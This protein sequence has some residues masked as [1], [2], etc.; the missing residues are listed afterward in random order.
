VSTTTH[1]SGPRLHPQ[2]GAVFAALDEHGIAWALLRGADELA[3]PQGDVDLLAD[4]RRW[5]DVVA[6][7]GAL[8][9]T[10]MP[11][12]GYGSHAF[13]LTYDP[14]TDS[15]IKLDIVTDLAFGP[16][17]TLPSRVEGPVLARR[18]RVDGVWMLADE[19][20]FWCLVLHKLLD[21]GA[22]P[23]DVHD[24]L[25][26]LAAAPCAE[27]PLAAVVDR[28]SPPGPSAHELVGHVR[29]G[30]WDELNGLAGSLRGGWLRHH[31]LTVLRRKVSH[32]FWKAAG[33]PLRRLRRQGITVA[34]LGPDGAGKS[35]AAGAIEGSFYF[36][37][38]TIYMGPGQPHSGR[39]TPP[40]GVG[41]ALRV[42]DQQRRWL[43][44]RG[45]TTRGQLVLFDRYSF[46]AMLPPRR[47]ISRIGR[48]RR[49]LLARSVPRPHLTIILDAPGELL[50]AR[51]GEQ[52][53]EILEA[54]R[55]SY[56][57]LTRRVPA[58]AVID[59]TQ[60]PDQVR[61]A[62]TTAIWRRWA[63]RWA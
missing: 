16:G 59:A 28:I 20:A 4:H 49:W 62:I 34:L 44:A 14:A 30:E 25:R 50:H 27:S 39:R 56:L 45:R 61:K 6:A 26:V 37:T 36:P 13:F 2:L 42:A 43:R 40:P 12:W 58:A 9:F 33:K 52:T 17:F 11:A 1:S 18:R 24:E 48:V 19:D 7:L 22:V 38:H 35:T 54:E 3:H 21:K 41:F 29:R 60:Q 57:S 53:P 32:R 51:K 46:D 5:R 10:R 23:A 63:H 8:G 31:R 15:W 55:K 47:R